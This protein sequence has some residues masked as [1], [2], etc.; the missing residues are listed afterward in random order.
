MSPRL[1]ELTSFSI[2]GA[3]AYV[4]DA[5][6]FNVLVHIPHAPLETKPLTAKVL[7]TLAAIV[8]AY[9]G[10][11]EWTWRDRTRARLRRELTLFFILN[12]VALIIAVVI[13]GFSRYV[14][15]FESA[16]ADNI[17]GN[18]IGVGLGT[19]F[20][21]WSYQRWIFKTAVS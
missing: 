12:F 19:L 15:G 16:L 5:G 20:R 10:N 4:I 6:G 2:V 9:Y 18:I 8:F 3:L 14:L 21:Y 13:L 1:R 11:R 17:S 7:S